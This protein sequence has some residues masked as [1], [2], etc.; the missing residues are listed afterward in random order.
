VLIRVSSYIRCPT[1]VHDGHIHKPLNVSPGTFKDNGGG[2]HKPWIRLP[3][4]DS[5]WSKNFNAL[6][7]SPTANRHAAAST[8]R[9]VY[10]LCG[11]R[12]GCQCQGSEVRGQ[13]LRSSLQGGSGS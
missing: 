8:A 10:A 11:F 6:A 12:V 13:E 2:V 3:S 4:C 5:T 1:R 7:S 9:P